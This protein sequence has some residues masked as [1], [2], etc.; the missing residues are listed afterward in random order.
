[1]RSG[2]EAGDLKETRVNLQQTSAELDLL[3]RQEKSRTNRVKRAL[4][5]EGRIWEQKVPETVHRD[6]KK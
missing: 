5:L 1:L 4:R 6:E 3:R 2:Q